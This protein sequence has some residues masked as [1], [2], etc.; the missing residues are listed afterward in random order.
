MRTLFN[1]DTRNQDLRAQEFLRVL[2]TNALA[3]KLKKNL[4]SLDRKIKFHDKKSWQKFISFLQWRICE[5][6]DFNTMKRE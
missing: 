1:I 4:L 3:L 6:L 2:P 5:K